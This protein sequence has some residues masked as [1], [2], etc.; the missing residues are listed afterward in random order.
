MVYNLLVH[1]HSV[2]RWILLISIV[3]ALIN[4][5]LK[6]AK[7]K[8]ATCDDC[9]FNRLTMVFAHIQLVAGT[10]LYFISPKVIF[11]AGSMKDSVLRFFLLE[12]ILL[13]IL[14]IVLITIG[15]I[16][17]DRSQDERKTFRYILIYFGIAFVLM[18]LS[19]LLSWG[20]LRGNHR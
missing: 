10:I 3:L 2:I 17:A 20:Q 8:K 18:L 1:I 13:M 4:A 19:I 12:H 5:I 7:H 6:L 15:Y 16:K 11:A 14:S 9:I